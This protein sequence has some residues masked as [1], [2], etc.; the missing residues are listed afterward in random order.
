MWC[1]QCWP[2]WPCKRA[3]EPL[4]SAELEEEASQYIL[5][6][7]LMAFDDAMSAISAHKG[8][9]Y[10]HYDNVG[11]RIVVGVLKTHLGLI[12]VFPAFVFDPKVNRDIPVVIGEYLGSRRQ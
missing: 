2:W 1:R 8:V 9:K 11:H 12:H 7:R 6:S 10:V 3:Q 5:M 4:W